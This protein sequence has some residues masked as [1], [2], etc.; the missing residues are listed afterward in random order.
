[1]IKD[2]SIVPTSSS[3]SI[4]ACLLLNNCPHPKKLVLIPRK[5][6]RRKHLDHASS[7]LDFVQRWASISSQI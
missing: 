4:D 3:S 6:Y 2:S 7:Y 1:L 5:T